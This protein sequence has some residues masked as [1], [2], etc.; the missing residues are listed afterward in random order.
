[1]NFGRSTPKGTLFRYGNK[2]R[3]EKL[4]RFKPSVKS[5]TKEIKL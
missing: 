2:Q 4:G 3:T 5:L 1:M